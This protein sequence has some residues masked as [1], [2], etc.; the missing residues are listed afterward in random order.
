VND[1]SLSPCEYSTHFWFQKPLIFILRLF[2]YSFSFVCLFFCFCAFPRYKLHELH[3]DWHWQNYSGICNV[4][5]TYLKSIIKWIVG[6]DWRRKLD[7]YKIKCSTVFI[8]GSPVDNAPSTSTSRNNFRN[9]SCE[10]FRKT[11]YRSGVPQL[12]STFFLLFLG[13]TKTRLLT[14]VTSANVC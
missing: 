5:P 12:S 8:S 13:T 6:F 1:D 2:V 11:C 4:A 14:S 10:Y 3:T 9:S 7:N